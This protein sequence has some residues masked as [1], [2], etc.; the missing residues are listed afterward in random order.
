MKWF[1]GIAFATSL[2]VMPVV[3]HSDSAPIDTKADIQK[4]AVTWMDAYNKKDA[5]TIAKMYTNDAVFSNP[6]WTASGRAAIE[7]SFNKEIAAGIF[8]SMTSITVDQSERVG[9]LNYSRGSWTAGMRG[10]D[11]KDVPVN[12]HW[13][14]VG[15]CQGQ[16]CLALIH[17]V[18]MALPPPK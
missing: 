16:D 13:L 14:I 4:L 10:P 17:N 18:N 1:A 9:D 8:T 3:A 2:I 15:K 7:D 11:G 6:G 5:T 12:G